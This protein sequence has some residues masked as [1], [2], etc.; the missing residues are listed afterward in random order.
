MMREEISAIAAFRLPTRKMLTRIIQ[1]LPRLPPAICGVG[2]QSTKVGERL[3]SNHGYEVC[4]V[5]V[6]QPDGINADCK[7]LFLKRHSS[8]ELMSA[9]GRLYRPGQTVLILQFSGY[10]LARWGLCFWIVNTLRRFL[11][12]H[13]DVRLMTMFHELWASGSLLST[14]GW[15]MLLQQR[16]VKSLV[17]LSEEVRTSRAEYANMIR[18]A[19]PSYSGKLIVQPIFS[20]LGEPDHMRDWSER[21]NQLVAF[22]PPSIDTPAGVV[23]WDS[24]QQLCER[25]KPEKTVVAGRTKTLPDHH[26]I[27]KRGILSAQDASALLSESRYALTQYFDGYLGKSS[28]LAAIA[29]HGLV[30]IMPAVNRSE[31]DGLRHHEHYLLPHDE[32]ICRVDSHPAIGLSLRNWYSSHNIATTAASYAAAIER[33]RR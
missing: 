16:I 14:A 28:L 11:R 23:Y 29:A 15:T 25:L 10:G 1:I 33:M 27:E 18:R 17:S 9:L 12:Q 19:C 32:A 31:A 24:W 22:Q 4:N 7:R 30:C 3:E 8:A 20:N 26:S 13:P 2:D 6:S 21:K 5:A